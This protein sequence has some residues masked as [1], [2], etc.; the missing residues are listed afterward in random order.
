VKIL[1][2]CGDYYPHLGGVTSL[3]DTIGGAL[4]QSG[5]ELT[6]L[7]RRWTSFPAAERWNGYD[8]LRVDYP[9]LFER[10]YFRRELVLR[11]PGILRRIATILR[12]RQI[13]T[14]CIGLLDLSALY[15]LLLRPL[16]KFRLV[17]YL[18]GSDVRVLPETQPTY[19]WILRKALL[20]ADAI[21]PVSQE[22]A[23]EAALLVPSA[24]R[25]MRV[26]TNSVDVAALRAASSRPHARP[27]IAFLG[28]LVHEKDVNTLI[29]AFHAACGKIGN[30][31]LLIGGSGREEPQLRAEAAAG[32]GSLQIHFLGDLCRQDCYSLLRGALFAVLPSRTE[33]HPIVAIEARV[34]GTPLIGSRI[35]GIARIVEDGRTGVLFPQGDV[36]ELAHLLEKYSTDRVALARLAA[37]AHESDCTA[38]DIRALLPR[39]LAAYGAPA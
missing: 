26:I 17:L 35:P 32:P 5:H 12:Q 36:A 9:M 21:V 16:L 30:V 34:A 1:F 2:A 18:H 27:Y 10:V 31:D 4:L 19:R 23:D 22:L 14:V 13:D 37:G 6:I 11:S 25:K 15:I 29:R 39:H 7:T 3:F 33:G 20:N 8:I 28:R 24:A 38:Y